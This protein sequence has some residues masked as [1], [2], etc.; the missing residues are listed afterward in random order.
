MKYIFVAKQSN[1]GLGCLIV[2]ICRSHT[3]PNT[4]GR[5]PLKEWSAFCR[6]CYPY[7][8]QQTLERNI[9]ALSG[10]WT[11]DPSN[12]V[13]ALDC[14]ATGIYYDILITIF[15]ML[16]VENYT[17]TRCWPIRNSVSCWNGTVLVPDRGHL[18][19]LYILK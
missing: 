19:F 5:T 16:L 8:T 1:L 11:H 3:H 6:D 13:Y 10:I 15:I 2:R 18:K 7:N 9:H 12:L 17:W 4:P 14:L